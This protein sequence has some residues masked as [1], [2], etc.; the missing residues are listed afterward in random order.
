MCCV[1]QL[2][3]VGAGATAVQPFVPVPCCRRAKAA[4]AV[5]P[6]CNCSCRYATTCSLC[7]CRRGATAGAVLSPCKSC[8]RATAATGWLIS[9]PFSCVSVANID[10]AIFRA[11]YASVEVT[12]VCARVMVGI[13]LAP[14]QNREAKKKL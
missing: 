9:V 4:G 1:V 7:R 14:I 13:K 11:A 10:C 6:R 12:Y 8:R 2:V 5:P 3:A